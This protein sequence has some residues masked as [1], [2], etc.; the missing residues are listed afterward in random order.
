MCGLHWAVV[1]GHFDAVKVLLDAGA[2]TNFVAEKNEDGKVFQFT[3]LGTFFGKFSEPETLLK[4]I[5]KVF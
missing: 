5:R 3:P 4:N 1:R 2:K